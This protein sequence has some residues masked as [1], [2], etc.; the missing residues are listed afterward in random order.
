M[1]TRHILHCRPASCRLLLA[2]LLAVVSACV[3][4]AVSARRTAAA[5]TIS[6]RRAFVE[7]PAT[8]LDLLS[9]S[10]RLDMLDYYDV[11]S[12]L[13]V[14][15]RMEGL[16]ELVKVTPDFIEVRV[17]PVSTMQLKVLTDRKSGAEVV[18]TLYTVGE[19]GHASDTEVQFYDSSL[20][21]LPRDR[22]MPQVRLRDL[23]DIPRGSLTSYKELEG[24]VPFPTVEYAV[25]PD[26]TGMTA[27]LTV[28]EYMDPDDYNIV[29]LFVRPAVH[30][31]WDGRR[32]RLRKE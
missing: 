16:S 6:V 14:S 18:M 4:A 9:R 12:I 23:L 2:A 1:T 15:N 13:R 20:R 3:P 8:T 17:T 5:D 24:M 7:L 29:K 28:G 31:D 19:E 11:D 26:S 22:F 25:S 32:Y 27:R 10:N 21:E 30:L